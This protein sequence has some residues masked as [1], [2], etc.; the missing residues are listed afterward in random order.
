M[1]TNL[2]LDA[3]LFKGLS[4]PKP[5]EVDDDVTQQESSHVTQLFGESSTGGQGA[6]GTRGG[7]PGVKCTFS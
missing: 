3:R 4:V 5:P 6:A 7:N 2:Y 1:S